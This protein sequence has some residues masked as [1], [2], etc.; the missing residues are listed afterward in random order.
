MASRRARTRSH[1]DNS[2]PANW[3]SSQLKDAL[4]E[5]G[6]NI[7]IQLSNSALRKLYLDNVD[8]R[9]NVQNIVQNSPDSSDNQTIIV[10]NN[11][12]VNNSTD[13][14]IPTNNDSNRVLEES[15]NSAN[16]NSASNSAPRINLDINT[17]TSAHVQEAAS[18]Q[19]NN[20]LL[21]NT[22]ELCQQ[23]LKQV[24]SRQ[25]MLQETI[26][27]FNLQSAMAASF[28]PHSTTTQMAEPALST[29]RLAQIGQNDSYRM[30]VYS[31]KSFGVPASS[32]SDT[33]M[34]SPEIRQNIITGKDVNL[35]SLLIPNY[36]IP[37]KKKTSENDDRLIRNLSLDEFII[38]FGRFKRIMCSAFPSR[39]EELELYLAHIVE[40]ANIWPYK[41]F[42]YHRMFSAKC[43]T[44]LLQHN[45]KIDWS[46]GDFELRQTICAGSKVNSC[47]FCSSTLHT[48]A[49]CQMK[50]S[51]QHAMSIANSSKGSD[52]L[53]RDIVWH[54]GQ[55]LCNNFSW[56]RG[57][58]KP[59][60]KYLHVCKLCKAKS[61]GKF[62]CI[63][64]QDSTKQGQPS[65]R[66][67]PVK[68]Q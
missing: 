15:V 13:V 62:N 21:I 53:G 10:T 27:S 6:I 55:Q 63:I 68:K 9:R 34:I 44:M 28:M 12:S 11:S 57:C 2:N 51:N 38:V 1:I 8:N 16:I 18:A 32:I 29:N 39:E 67:A 61:H 60:C 47:S 24:N 66:P 65:Q 4:K 50:T 19:V 3:T 22:I 54:E 33:D 7:S 35:N 46:K 26:P 40:T 59:Y 31:V 49:M 42:E 36:E 45:L 17:P 20:M 5:L 43:A 37:I 52:S 48:S 30:P 64:S 25:S 56:A 23:T 41:F 58:Q 14:N